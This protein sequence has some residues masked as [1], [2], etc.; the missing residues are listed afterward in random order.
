MEAVPLTEPSAAPTAGR[1]LKFNA[2]SVHDESATERTDVVSGEPLD[3]PVVVVKLRAAPTTVLPARADRS[4][5]R[6]VVFTGDPSTY[7]A[8]SV[9]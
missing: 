6:Y 8:V 1:L 9:P 3:V 5:F 4:Y 2:A 7:S